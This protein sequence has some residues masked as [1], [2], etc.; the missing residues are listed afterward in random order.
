MIR[1]W[2]IFALSA[3]ILTA[4]PACSETAE[5]QAHEARMARLPPDCA[6]RFG[7]A[8]ELIE[9]SIMEGD[10][11]ALACAVEVWDELS[12]EP[13]ELLYIHWRVTG[14][15]T[16]EL[17]AQASAMEQES[18]AVR[19]YGFHMLNDFL[20]PFEASP[21]TGCT[22]FDEPARS[23]ILTGQG[24]PSRFGCFPGA[25]PPD[26]DEVEALMERMERFPADCAARFPQRRGLADAVD[27]GDAFGLHCAIEA[28]GDLE[29]EA[30]ELRY[31]YWRVT[32]EEPAGL[33]AMARAMEREDLIVR[34]IDLHER[35]GFLPPIPRHPLRGCPR[36]DAPARALIERGHGAR[37]AWACNRFG[38]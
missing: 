34:I 32:G 22:V 19:I 24:P 33:D 27:A 14:V 26:D 11:F 31:I 28:W 18:L 15:K 29:T 2:V 35:Y 3:L 13:L 10:A 30:F 4:A 7:G 37:P 20:A 16:P 38:F 23:L 21:E 9:I 5:W 12:N 17:E 1:G 25:P 6:E 8:D 36:F